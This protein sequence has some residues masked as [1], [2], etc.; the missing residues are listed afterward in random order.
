MGKWW[1]LF[2][3]LSVSS[4]LGSGVAAGRPDIA[5]YVLSNASGQICLL[6]IKSACDHERPEAQMLPAKNV[7]LI[8]QAG[9]GR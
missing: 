3:L 2:L 8:L 4:L 7:S 5:V 6:L 1:T 9:L